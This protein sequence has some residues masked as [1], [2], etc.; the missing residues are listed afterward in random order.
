MCQGNEGALGA[1]SHYSD[2]GGGV[3]APLSVYDDELPSTLR[4]HLRTLIQDFPCA[5]PLHLST[6]HLIGHESD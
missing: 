6:L 2:N 5:L 3:G 1:E 4:M